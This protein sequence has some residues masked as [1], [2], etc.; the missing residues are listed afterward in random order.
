M[1]DETRQGPVTPGSD[2]SPKNNQ[3][4]LNPNTKRAGV[5]RTFIERGEHGL[6]CFEAVRLAHDY[7]L[8][9]TF[10]DLKRDYGLEFLRKWEQI[11]GHN[12]SRVECVRYW[13][14][15]DCARRVQEMLGGGGCGPQP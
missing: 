6:N 2:R 13:L 3:L 15:P 8:R 10:S 5:L 11:P 4:I 9:S 7:V 14:A 12:G 1:E